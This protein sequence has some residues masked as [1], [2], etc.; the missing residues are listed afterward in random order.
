MADDFM[1]FFWSCFNVFVIQL[2]VKCIGIY[3][4]II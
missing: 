4:R 1:Y 2:S 3:I